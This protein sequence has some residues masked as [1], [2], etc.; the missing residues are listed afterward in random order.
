MAETPEIKHFIGALLLTITIY[1]RIIVLH[2]D[3]LD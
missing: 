3:W 2:V 1:T